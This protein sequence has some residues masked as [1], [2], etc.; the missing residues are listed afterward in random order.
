MNW[1]CY[2]HGKLNKS[3]NHKIDYQPNFT[4]LWV[5]LHNPKYIQLWTKIEAGS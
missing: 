5:N 3:S 2:K 4:H 1:I